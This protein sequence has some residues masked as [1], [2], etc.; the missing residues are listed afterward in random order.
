M[1]QPGTTPAP[2][3]PPGSLSAQVQPV[4]SV[5]ELILRPW[6]RADAPEIVRAYADDEIHRWHARS[7]SLEQAQA[8][9]DFERSRWE[10]EQGGSWAITRDTTVLGR[11]G[12]GGVSLDEARAGV[13]YW[14]LPEARGRGV[15]ARALAAVAEWAFDDIGFHRMELDHSTTNPA[16]CRVATRAGFVAEGIA[17]ARALHLDGWHDMHSHGLLAADPRP[18]RGTRPAPPGPVLP[19]DPGG[20]V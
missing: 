19:P 5:R 11:V 17:R 12:I 8:W 9:V 15:A 3:L 18:A 4:L 7:M 6:A 20:A 10:C 2:T 13:T 1:T 16:S 14:V